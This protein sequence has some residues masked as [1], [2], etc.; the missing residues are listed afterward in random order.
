MTIRIRHP[1][2]LTQI[3]MRRIVKK[4]LESLG[5][6]PPGAPPA[7]TLKLSMCRVASSSQC[8]S[9]LRVRFYR[10][11]ST[12]ARGNP[13]GNIAVCISQ[14]GENRQFFFLF[15]FFRMYLYAHRWEEVTELRRTV[16]K[17][18]GNRGTLNGL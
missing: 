5:S 12:F 8:R 4:F 7:A 16:H 15:F 17:S 11:F 13:T 14:V 10:F 3:I 2:L 1:A 18:G 9:R 6:D